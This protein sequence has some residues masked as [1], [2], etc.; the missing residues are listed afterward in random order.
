MST[1]R[2]S[3]YAGAVFQLLTCPI[4]LIGH[5]SKP[6]PSN[7]KEKLLLDLVAN[8]K[9]D[10]G[11]GFIRSFGDLYSGLSLQFSIFIL[12]VGLINVLA[13][14][15]VR[16]ARFLRSLC[17]LNAVFMGFLSVNAFVHFF[18]PPLTLFVLPFIAFLLAALTAPRTT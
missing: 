16:E 15:Q 7:E 17:W 13:I 1:F 8:Y 6:A 14:R 3:F 10:L 12:M 2:S 4:H 9:F 5:F 11:G 18:I